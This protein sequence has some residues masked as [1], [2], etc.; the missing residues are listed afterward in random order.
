MSSSAPRDLED[1]RGLAKSL[2]K[3]LAILDVIGMADTPLKVSEVAL[4]TGFSRPTCHRLVQ[5]L[6]AEGYVSQDPQTAVVSAGFSLLM[7]T[8]GL[9]DRNRMRLEALP[10]LQSLSNLT[11]ERTNLGILHRDRVLYLAG[12]EKPSL[13]T[14]YSRFGKTAPAHCCSLGKAILAHLPEAEVQ[15]VINAQPLQP[16]T[17]HSITSMPRFWEELEATRKRGFAIDQQEHMPGSTCIAATIISKNRAVGAIGI[18][19]LSLQQLEPFVPVLRHTAELISHV[20]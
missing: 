12:V 11:G 10:H 5:T 17:R 1:D 7:L 8:A 16:V 18:S 13:P 3:A 2:R 6:I 20:L 4:R 9:L 14:I 19:G 15:S